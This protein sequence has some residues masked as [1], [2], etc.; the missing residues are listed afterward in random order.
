[1]PRQIDAFPRNLAVNHNPTNQIRVTAAQIKHLQDEV[2]AALLAAEKMFVN[3]A[4]EAI[5]AATGLDLVDLVAEAQNALNGISA[6]F[7]QSWLSFQNLL[8]GIVDRKSVV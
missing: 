7:Q 3:S 8:N 1:M 2:P 5:D 4:L 6:A